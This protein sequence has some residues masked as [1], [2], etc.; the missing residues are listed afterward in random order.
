L[1]P[2]A[3]KTGLLFWEDAQCV[4]G[5]LAACMVFVQGFSLK[6]NAVRVNRNT[7]RGTNSRHFVRFLLTYRA[8]NFI[9]GKIF[10]E[11]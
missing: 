9:V 7:F 10:E 1:A 4:P 5:A 3:V 11:F 2:C 8:L 6:K